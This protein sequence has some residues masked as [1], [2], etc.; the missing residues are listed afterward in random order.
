[1]ALNLLVTSHMLLSC[2]L[3]SLFWGGLFFG[4]KHV[5]FCTFGA[6]IHQHHTL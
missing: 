4:K 1:M 2:D 3:L 6:T 5:M